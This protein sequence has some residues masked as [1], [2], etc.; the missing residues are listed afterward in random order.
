M[1]YYRHRFDTPRVQ[2]INER[3]L[4]DRAKWLAKTSQVDICIF[5]ALKLICRALVPED[6]YVSRLESINE[7]DFYTV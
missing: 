5:V 3:H 2:E 4:Y 1:T 6:E 7:K